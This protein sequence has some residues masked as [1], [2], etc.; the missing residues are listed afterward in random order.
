VA[1]AAVVAVEETPGDIRLVA[2]CEAPGG[3]STDE[4]RRH[5]A[6]WVPEYMVPS[7]FVVLDELP[8]TPSGKVDRQALP[9]LGE[10][11]SSGDASYVAPR[12]ALEEAVAAI[13]ADV[14]GRERV[15]V[16]DDFFALGGHSL[17]A[18]QV[19]A[20]VRTDFAI[21]LP[22]HSLF[23][24]PTVALLSAEIVGMMGEAESEETAKLLEELEGLT[25]EE[26]S[27]LVSEL[28]GPE[29]A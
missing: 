22:L 12:T 8:L 28:G 5:V 24:S 4:L 29:G 11:A 26:A 17:L 20:Q 7:A 23:M 2:Y 14:L 18:T 3:T 16:E 9:E 19:V 27:Q 6:E 13:W 21:E 25:D 15:G 10:A 1:N